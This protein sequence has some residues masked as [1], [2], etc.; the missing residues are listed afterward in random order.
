MRG[1]ARLG[2]ALLLSRR[3]PGIAACMRVARPVGTW[4]LVSVGSSGRCRPAMEGQG[5]G[6]AACAR[7]Q[8]RARKH[9]RRRNN[10]GVCAAASRR[11]ADKARRKRESDHV[12]AQGHGGKKMYMHGRHA[13]VVRRTQ[14]TDGMARPTADAAADAAA[15]GP[16]TAGGCIRRGA[17]EEAPKGEEEVACSRAGTSWRCLLCSAEKRLGSEGARPRRHAGGHGRGCR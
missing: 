7:G 10:G 6:A 3:L 15:A 11:D 5:S 9:R 13:C 14:T 1:I 16:G 12:D 8:G 2:A 4:P 17:V